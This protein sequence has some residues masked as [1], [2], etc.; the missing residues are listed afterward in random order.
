VSRDRVLERL[1]PSLAGL[2]RPLDIAAA[3][4]RKLDR[5]RGDFQTT[6]SLPIGKAPRPA[7]VLVPV[8]DRPEGLGVLLT[9]RTQNLQNHAGQI[10]FPGGRIEAEDRG[11]VATA[12]RE[13]EE[14]IGL[15]R[16]FVTVIGR[17]DDY[18]TGTGFVVAPIVG[19]VRAPYPVAPDPAEVAEVFEV[20][21]A[22]FLEPANH[23]RETALFKG[24]QRSFYAMPYDGRYIW[25]ATAAMLLNLY[26]VLKD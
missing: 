9:Q 14:E 2:D 16:D 8:V 18:I 3:V 11:A 10:S 4:E 19:L 5:F 6:P 7:A 12:L 24:M 20:P 26:D 22:H 1:R 17:L 21:L 23:K 13:T 15:P 25:G